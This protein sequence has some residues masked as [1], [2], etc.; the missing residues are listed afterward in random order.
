MQALTYK[1]LLEELQLLNEQQ[2]AQNVT[3]RVSWANEFFPVEFLDIADD[4]QDV[5]DLGHLIL[6]I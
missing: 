3:V 2:L 4:D 6:V 1:Q 5:L